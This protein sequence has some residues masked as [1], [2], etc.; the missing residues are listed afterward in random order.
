MTSRNLGSIFLVLL[1]L[2]TAARAADRKREDRKRGRE[3]R[4]AKRAAR[5]LRRERAH[6][7]DERRHGPRPAFD[8]ARG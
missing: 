1:M 6:A 8:S 4:N 3:E 7:G 5:E 2:G